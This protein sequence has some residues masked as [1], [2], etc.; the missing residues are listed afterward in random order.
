MTSDN[1]QKILNVFMALDKD[2][3]GNLTSDELIEAFAEAGLPL[4]GS[5]MEEIIAKFDYLSTGKINYTDFLAATI[6]LKTLAT[7]AVLH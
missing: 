6:N 3:N 2:K 7:D 4:A 1:Y 5:E